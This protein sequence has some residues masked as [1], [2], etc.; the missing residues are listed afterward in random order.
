MNPSELTFDPETATF[1]DGNGKQWI[2]NLL[3][4][5][6]PIYIC[7][8][9]PVWNMPAPTSSGYPGHID[10]RVINLPPDL[11]TAIKNALVAILAK[12]SSG[13]LNHHRTLLVKISE[14]CASS[15]ISVNFLS[16]VPE[17]STLWNDWLSDCDRSVL[18]NLYKHLKNNGTPGTSSA[19]YNHLKSWKARNKTQV[20]RAVLEWN[21]KKGALTSSELEVL[22]QEFAK[23]VKHQ[24]TLSNSF[25]RIMVRIFISTF[26][27]TTQVLQ[28]P[29]DGLKRIVNSNGSELAFLVTPGA[30]AQINAEPTWEPIPI[31]LANEIESYRNRPE[32]KAHANTDPQLLFAV[33][34]T[35]ERSKTIASTI[36]TRIQQW[37]SSK[38]LISPRTGYLMKI[39]MNRLRHTGAT[40]LAM[41]GY[42]RDIIQSVL[43]HDSAASAQFYIDSVGADTTPVLERV[44]RKLGGRFS[45]LK[46][47]FFKGVIVSQEHTTKAPIVLPTQTT[48]SIVGACGKSGSCSLHPL[49]SCYSCEHFLAFKEADHTK[50][51]TYLETESK[52]WHSVEYGASRGKSIKD[53]QRLAAG[54]QEL[55]DRID[56]DAS[57]GDD[58][59]DSE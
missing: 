56:E 14:A 4:E 52:A 10:W 28:I 16:S 24:E 57:E 34:Q 32:V 6:S 47:A 5:R 58:K 8:D 19:T 11:V 43:Q 59:G 44:D 29:H 45:D 18:R 31:S 42:S 9:E 51:L 2:R 41:Q 23:P 48:P 36:S 22:L 30:K 38:A 39:T 20:L 1:V 13:T 25:A 26:R 55:I 53:F 54:V 17:L 3:V 50:V 37:V 7:I 15:A 21:P 33:T 46:N 12:T 49:L 40:Q 35:G 27:R